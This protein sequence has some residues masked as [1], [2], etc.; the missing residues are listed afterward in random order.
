VVLAVTLHRYDVEYEGP[1]LLR[2]G[3][4]SD[5]RMLIVAAVAVVTATWTGLRTS[6]DLFALTC[7]ALVSLLVARLLVVSSLQVRA[8]L[9]LRSLRG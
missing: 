4:G 3:L 6:I 9:R 8:A 2:L 1:R 7:V 5:G